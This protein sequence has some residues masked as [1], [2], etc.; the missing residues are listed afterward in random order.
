MPKVGIKGQTYFNSGTHDTPVWQ[1]AK[2]VHD[3]TLSLSKG[4]V[5]VKNKGSRWVKYLSALNDV[6]LDLEIDWEPG[7]AVF[8]ALQAA[9]WSE[10][11]VE[12]VILDGGIRK[13]GAQG[14]RAGFMVTK[15]ERSEPLEDEMLGNISL[16]LHADWAYEPDW[17]KVNEGGTALT[18]VAAF[19]DDPLNE[20][21]TPPQP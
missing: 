18:S 21:P 9:F 7:H 15:F 4:E 1:R 2:I 6:P 8:D 13:P 10:E 12:F 20:P 17:V 3:L 19:A 14:L 11:A 16:R 5:Q